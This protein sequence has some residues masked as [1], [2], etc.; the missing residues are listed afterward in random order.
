MKKRLS[1][2]LLVGL[3]MG[4]TLSCDPILK[5]LT[6]KLNWQTGTQF[7]GFYVAQSLGYYAAQGI[8][9]T[10]EP[11]SNIAE[12]GLVP[13]RVAA[14]EFQFGTGGIAL[15]RAQARGVPIT[16]ISNIYKLSPQTFFA[17][18]DSGIVTPEDL[19]HRRIAVKNDDWRTALQILLA[20]VGLN[21]DS[22]VQVPS[23]FDMTPFFQG[24]VE[25][26]AGFVTEEVVRARQRG[27]KL[28]TLPLY[29]YGFRVFAMTV[30]TSQ[31]WLADNPEWAVRFL[32]GSLR[33]WLWALDN[34][35]K[36]VDILLEMYPE[37]AK[38]R[39]FHLA[40]FASSIPLIRPQGSQVGAI[41]CRL[42]EINELL[43]NLTSKDGLCDDTI[44]EA[45]Y[46]SLDPLSR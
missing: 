8:E 31:Q 10:I 46:K 5:S 2:I 24:D 39:D 3:L 32:Q 17:R 13:E 37:L 23:G 18:A 25:V 38:E 35:V 30:F 16:A 22:V 44:F 21:L 14:G 12:A 1:Q 29:E 6:L 15:M 27:L 7:I 19:A 41:D 28:V 43:E 40:S 36:A 4:T 34:P 11:S 26:W 20:Y 45:A 9:L 33:G 42:W